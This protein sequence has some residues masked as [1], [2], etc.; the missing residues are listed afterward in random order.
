MLSDHSV[1][2]AYL[3]LGKSYNLFPWD[4]LPKP[5]NQ[6]INPSINR[7]S[8]YQCTQF[9]FTF[10][11]RSYRFSWC[12]WRVVYCIVMMFTMMVGFGF[13]IAFYMKGFFSFETS[14]KYTFHSNDI[15]RC[16]FYSPKVYIARFTLQFFERKY[17]LFRQ[18][19]FSYYDIRNW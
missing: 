18:L 13:A 9:L 15:L 8:Q 11:L 19:P 14:C 7:G 1:F 10:A 17:F 2:N 12:T 6:S 16:L 5:I 3:C 4:F